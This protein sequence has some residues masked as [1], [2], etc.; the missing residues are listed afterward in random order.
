MQA[1]KKGSV[2]RDY[3]IDVRTEDIFLPSFAD[4]RA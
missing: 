3:G 2:I 4:L 1:S